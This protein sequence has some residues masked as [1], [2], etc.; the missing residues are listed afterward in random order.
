LAQK[1][2]GVSRKLVGFDEIEKGPIP[3]HGYEI[4][5][6]AG[7]TI[8]VITSGTMSPS[9][10]KPI[11]MGYVARDYMKIGTEV[12]IMIRNKALKAKVAKFPF[13]QIG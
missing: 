9:M 10:N 11:A 13:L 5:N 1:E 3:R 4:Q 12:Q 8:G 6:L 7:E 2:A